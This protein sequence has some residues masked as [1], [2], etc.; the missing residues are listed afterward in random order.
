MILILFIVTIDPIKI[1]KQHG[2][3]VLFVIKTKFKCDRILYCIYFT[4]LITLSL[5][6]VYLYSRNNKGFACSACKLR[7]GYSS[8]VT[9]ANMSAG[10]PKSCRNSVIIQKVKQY[11]SNGQPEVP[12]DICI[13]N[14]GRTTKC[15]FCVRIIACI[16]SRRTH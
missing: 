3:A 5:L 4:V 9:L 12:S 14:C 15:V 11:S 8:I 16:Y 1:A 7:V 13:R 6:T 2:G 10:Q